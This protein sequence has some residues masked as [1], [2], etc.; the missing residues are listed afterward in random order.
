MFASGVKAS[1]SAS[2]IVIS[3]GDIAAYDYQ[4]ADFTW[5]N[6]WRVLDLTGKVAAGAIEAYLRIT[7]GHSSAGP[8]M[9]FRKNGYSNAVNG[10]VVSVQ[11][12][13]G[14]REYARWIELDS[15]GKT[16]YKGQ[17]AP[18]TFTMTVTKSLI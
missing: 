8:N 3:R 15:D 14:T 6:T 12:V 13:A 4:T 9:M 7:M 11:A 10:V 16:E 5:D 18:G 2:A 1:V 17:T